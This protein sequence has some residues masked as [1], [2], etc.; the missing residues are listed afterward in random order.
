M[1]SLQLWQK[2]GLVRV[3]LFMQWPGAE[4]WYLGRT[5]GDCCALFFTASGLAVRPSAASGSAGLTRPESAM[6]SNPTTHKQTHRQQGHYN[7]PSR[8]RVIPPAGPSGATQRFCPAESAPRL[9]CLSQLPASQAAVLKYR[10]CLRAPERTRRSSGEAPRCSSPV[11]VVF[12][13]R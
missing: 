13:R 10:P 9:A 12:S 7:R 11:D 2:V 5:P 6:S 1:K 4:L 8:Q 3:T